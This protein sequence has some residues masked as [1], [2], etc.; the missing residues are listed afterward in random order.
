MR[1]TARKIDILSIA[2]ASAVHVVLVLGVLPW[3]LG[4]HAHYWA[5][6]FPDGYDLIAQNLVD[7]NGYRYF[8]DTALTLQRTP[9]YPLLLAAIFGVFGHQLIAA[10]RSQRREF[11]CGS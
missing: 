10:V 9:A 2:L 5:Q 11:E 3:A 1:M 8:S 7:G 4:L 6:N